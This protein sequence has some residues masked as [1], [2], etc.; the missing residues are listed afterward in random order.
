MSQVLRLPRNRPETK[1]QSLGLWSASGSNS[2]QPIILSK[3][4]RHMHGLRLRS[5]NL[6]LPV[7]LM[8]PEAPWAISLWF[9]FFICKFGVIIPSSHY[10]SSI[11]TINICESIY[12]SLSNGKHLANISRKW[13]TVHA[14]A[15][16]E[17]KSW[18]GLPHLQVL[19]LTNAFVR[20]PCHPNYGLPLRWRLQLSTWYPRL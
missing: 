13:W 1:R 6:I 19:I 15:K 4:R 11:K 2:L 10:C 20:L 8:W 5:L 3:N 9:N 17:A 7:T 18:S 14:F 16:G 12:K